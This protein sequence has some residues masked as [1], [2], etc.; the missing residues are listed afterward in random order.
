MIRSV[1]GP[2]EGAADIFAQVEALPGFKA[3][4]TILVYWSI[5]GE[6]ETHEFIARWHGTKRIVL[7]KVCGEGIMEL[8]EYA[9]EYMQEGY[10]GI[11]EPS[12]SAPLVPA[13]EIGFAVIPGMAFDRSGGRLGRGKGY[14]DR[15]LPSLICLKAAVAYGHQLVEEVPVEAHDVRMDMVITPNNSYI[16]NS[17]A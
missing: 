3:A 8:R 7:P 9:P 14:Y 16:C 2:F 5:P 12:D 4:D 15:L 10:R 17:E 6:V 1:R 13:S 11:M